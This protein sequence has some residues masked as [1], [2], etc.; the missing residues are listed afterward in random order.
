M[1]GTVVLRSRASIRYRHAVAQNCDNVPTFLE[2]ST[3]ENTLFR[4]LLAYVVSVCMN[5]E[6]VVSDEG[7]EQ[8]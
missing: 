8:S 3:Q 5:T 2:L 6:L 1:A 4:V 7:P